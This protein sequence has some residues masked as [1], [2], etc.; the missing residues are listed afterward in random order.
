MN[1]EKRS[2]AA[3]IIGII[4]LIYAIVLKRHEAAAIPGFLA[5][6]AATLKTSKTIDT[7]VGV[8]MWAGIIVS[9]FGIWN[10][11]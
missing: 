3:L 8:G 2:P 4:L 5:E 9:L 10:L 11:V 6:L 1:G 7:Q